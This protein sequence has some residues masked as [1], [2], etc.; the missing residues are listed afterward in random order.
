MGKR[1]GGG[2]LGLLLLGAGACYGLYY[3]ASHTLRNNIGRGDTFMAITVAIFLALATT[4]VGY[5]FFAWLTS[6]RSGVVSCGTSILLS[7]VTALVLVGS[8]YAYFTHGPVHLRPSRAAYWRAVSQ[9]C[10]GVGISEAHAYVEGPGLHKV[11]ALEPRATAAWPWTR[12]LP[13]EWRPAALAE[14]ELVLCLQPEE[15]VT[16]EVCKYSGDRSMNRYQYRR[17]GQLR[18]AQTGEVIGEMVLNG[19]APATCPMVTSDMVDKK[20]SHVTNDMVTSW[21]ESYVSP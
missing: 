21:L 20:G 11:E 2:T 18:A 6:R 9:V 3:V 8:L 14:T 12:H 5:F 15:K 10:E 19:T 17:Q 16:I 7:F 1:D 4:V 13:K